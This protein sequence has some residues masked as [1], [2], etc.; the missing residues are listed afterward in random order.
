[1]LPPTSISCWSWPSTRRDVSY[2]THYDL[3]GYTALVQRGV[4]SG[5][6]PLIKIHGSVASV[7]S[8]IDTRKQRRQGRGAALNKVLEGLLVDHA[9]LYVGFSG[10]DLAFD[11][12]Y[13]G[14]RDAADRSPGF[15]FLHQPGTPLHPEIADLLAHY[16]AEKANSIEVDGATALEQIARAAGASLPPPLERTADPPTGPL[17]QARIKTWAGGLDQWLAARM[18]AS[19]QEAAS[20]HP[21]ALR[22]LKKA[23]CAPSNKSPH[24]PNFLVHWVKGRVRRARYDDPDVADA[25]RFLTGHQHP[26]A[27]FFA[28]VTT[29]FTQAHLRLGK[30]VAATCRE[31]AVNYQQQLNGMSATD[32]VDAVLLVCDAASLFEEL[33]ELEAALGFACEIAAQDGDDV[34]QALCRAELAVRLARLGR[35]DEVEALYDAAL[36]IATEFHEHRIATTAAC[37]R[38]LASEHSAPGEAMG[39]AQIAYQAAVSDELRLGMSRALLTGLRV[40]CRQGGSG[41][42]AEVEAR[43]GP[44]ETGPA[45]ELWAHDLERQLYLAEF[46]KRMG[47]PSWRSELTNIQRQARHAG[48]A[49]IERDASRL[50]PPTDPASDDA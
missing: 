14:I 50:L 25:I 19:L 9:F 7:E 32:A 45:H 41:N 40:A 30:T 13:L 37:A 26:L 38:A 17:V 8:L 43:L 12:H 21:N 4:G 44:S 35:G 2:E 23:R 27:P 28:L 3:D 39:T 42:V 47:E 29:A 18:A 10:S 22:L 1:M 36:G 46:H 15:C 11:K 48:M 5:P 20:L 6:L 49:W 33:P 34:R 24:Y 31:F 16:G